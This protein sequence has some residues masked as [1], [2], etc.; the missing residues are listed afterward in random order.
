MANELGIATGMTQLAL[1]KV[2]DG[3]EGQDQLKHYLERAVSALS[4]L[5]ESTDLLRA[6]ERDRAGL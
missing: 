6:Q 1:R 3:I 5:K 2:E 4:R